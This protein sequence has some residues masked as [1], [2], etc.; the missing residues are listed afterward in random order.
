MDAENKDLLRL[1]FY[2]VALHLNAVI[3]LVAVT[4]IALFIAPE[5]YRLPVVL[6]MI[7]L[8]AYLAITF[9]RKYQETRAWLYEHAGEE[10]GEK[11]DKKPL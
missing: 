4:V 2:G 1:K 9:R 7:L 10:K 11:G 8:V 5:P 6:A 3:L